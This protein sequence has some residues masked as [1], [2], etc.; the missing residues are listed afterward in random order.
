M[1]KLFYIPLEKD[2]T[3]F[4]QFDLL[5]SDELK[6]YSKS[7]YQDIISAN[8]IEAEGIVN[9]P[10]GRYSTSV[11]IPKEK[12]MNIYFCL[13]NENNYP[14]NSE[15]IH[16]DENLV[17]NIKKKLSIKVKYSEGILNDQIIDI[18]TNFVTPRIKFK[19]SDNISYYNYK[20][21]NKSC[22]I[23]GAPGSGKTTLLRRLT[24]DYLNNALETEQ[25]LTKFPIY[26]QLRDFNNYSSNFETFI[27]NCIHNT[28]SNIQISIKN[29]ISNTGNLYLMLDG[30]DE[31]DFE[32][33]KNFSKSITKYKKRNPHTSFIITSRPDRNFEKIKDFQKCYVQ[34]FDKNQIKELTYRKFSQKEKWKDYIS[35]LNSVPEVYDVLKNPLLLTISHFLY[36]HKSILPINSGQL[37]KELVAT[38]VSNWD[39]QR[40]IERKWK[41][42]K[43]NPIEITHTLGKIALA[44]SEK[45]KQKIKTKQLHSLFKT[46]DSQT[47]FD[48]YLKYIEFATGLIISDSEDY[49][50]FNHK[51]IQDYFCSNYLVEK[52][53]ELDKRVFVD[54]DWDEILQMI[55]GLSSDPNYIINSIL[56]ETSRD[57]SEKIKNSIS[58]YNESVLLTKF[59]VEKSY[60]LLEKYFTDFEKKN[61]LSN[62]NIKSDKD[63][64]SIKL[65]K[66]TKGFKEVL[67]I[68]Y[69]LLK[70]RFTK[71][72]YD[73][74][75]Y[76]SKSNS[77]ILKSISKF[78]NDKGNI[79]VISEN[80]VTN[81]SQEIESP[82][83]QE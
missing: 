21:F 45:K 4:F 65:L 26:I 41:N 73:F 28:I 82:N 29:S 23:F 25:R 71:Y 40:S 36:L 39:S 22:I 55:S 31:I 43:V 78:S 54:K 77:K 47:E 58:V 62:R 75:G 9:L 69:V 24:I 61:N 72:E 46:Y 7:N 66:E 27:D 15:E 49:W 30:A 13:V 51:S 68:V 80:N 34:P 83:I 44:I 60:N 52:V 19:D 35:I 53:G 6:E 3:E 59:D 20:S 81:I 38:L 57:K 17:S 16:I 56:K 33:F 48:E 11:F 74:N 18:L 32:K 64:M 10:N 2:N 12:H 42:T 76:F 14:V 70:I 5:N 63:K 1:E 8:F 50:M 37:M 67:S 79:N